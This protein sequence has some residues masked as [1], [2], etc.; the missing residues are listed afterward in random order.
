[1]SYFLLE[2]GEEAPT[3]VRH[4]RS[5][6]SAINLEEKSRNELATASGS[7]VQSANAHLILRSDF[8]IPS[9]PKRQT[10]VSFKD[11]TEEL[12]NQ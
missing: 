1:M 6:S 2:A 3:G 5:G 4:G 9:I 11:I 12:N 7:R 10:E 8:M